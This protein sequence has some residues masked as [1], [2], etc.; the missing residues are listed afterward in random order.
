M[1]KILIDKSNQDYIENI[2]IDENNFAIIME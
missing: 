1:M 2:I